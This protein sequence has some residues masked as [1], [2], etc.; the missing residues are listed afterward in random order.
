MHT[1]SRR[2]HDRR[3]GLHFGIRMCVSA[4]ASDDTASDDTASDDTASDDTASDDTASDDT[5]SDDACDLRHLDQ[6][7]H[8]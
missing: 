2:V 7:Q 8:L 5:A 3:L 1:L 4:T 6:V